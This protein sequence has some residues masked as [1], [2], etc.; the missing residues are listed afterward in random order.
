MLGPYRVLDLTDE[1][2]WFAGMLLAQLGADVVLVEPAG[3]WPRDG[4]SRYRHLVY[5]R[6]KR[7]ITIADVGDIDH[8]AAEADIVLDNGGLER[9]DLGA[10]GQPPSV[11]LANLRSQNPEL[12]TVRTTPWGET[13]PKAGWRATDLTLFAS[14]GQLAVTGDSDRPPVRISLPQAWLHAESQAA[15]AA[16]VALEHRARTGRGQHVDLS[17]QEAV[18]ETALSASLFAPAGLAEVGRSAGGV[19]SGTLQ[20]RSIFACLDGHVVVTIAFGPMIGPMFQR[21]LAWMAEE[22]AIDPDTVAKDWVDY[23]IHVQEGLE[24]ASTI[25]RVMDQVAEFAATKTKAQFQERGLADA[26]LVCPVNNLQDVLDSPQ[27]A[28]R[29]FWDDHDGVRLPGRLV[30]AGASPLKPLDPAPAPDQ[31]RHDLD[32]SPER[33]GWRSVQVPA[34]APPP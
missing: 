24:T 17:A 27:L 10:Q 25:E 18:C 15:V 14:S 23:P 9:S 20:M 12:I 19:R 22:G 21:F 7:S 5:N 16:L 28:D 29:Q 2:G 1:Q 11:D 31:H 33:T 4:G 8:L 32:P 30:A 6:G 34:A 26:L 13:G 3:G